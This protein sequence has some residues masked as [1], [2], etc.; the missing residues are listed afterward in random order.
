MGIGPA[1]RDSTRGVYPISVVSE[2]TGLGPQTLRLYETK[3]L[4]SPGRTEGGIRRY[5]DDDLFRLRRITAL[6]E[7]GLNL[8]GI[9]RV[10][11]LEHELGQLREQLAEARR[12]RAAPTAG[13][14]R[15]QAAEPGRG[16]GTPHSERRRVPRER[17]GSSAR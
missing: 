9:R 8:A 6:T 3:G 2:L 16:A 1:E 12:A 15:P 7:A 14:R 11:E 13:G 10:L 5:S 17:E 4:L